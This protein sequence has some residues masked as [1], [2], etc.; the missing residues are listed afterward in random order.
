MLR[1]LQVAWLALSGRS[2]MLRT[3]VRARIA[4][5]S[6][7]LHIY[8][9]SACSF[10]DADCNRPRTACRHPARAGGTEGSPAG[11]CAAVPPDRYCRN[12]GDLRPPARPH[13]DLQQAARGHAVLAGVDLQDP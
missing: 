11:C 12:D 2:P 13:A 1:K 5:P 3:T 6:T 8:E 4:I 7:P 10:A 9:R